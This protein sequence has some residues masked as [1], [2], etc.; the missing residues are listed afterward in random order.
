MHYDFII[1]LGQHPSCTNR[2]YLEVKQ[3][4]HSISVVLKTLCISVCVQ[5]HAHLLSVEM[6][7]ESAHAH[8]SFHGMSL[9]WM[10]TI[11]LQ[12]RVNV[13]LLTYNNNYASIFKL[14]GC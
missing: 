14:K 10:V 13:V 12:V 3:G 1:C 8:Q 11:S 2:G 7:R 9:R 6:Y 4:S 5:S